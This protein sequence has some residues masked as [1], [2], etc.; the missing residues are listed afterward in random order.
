MESVQSQM[1]HLKELVSVSLDQ[2]QTLLK[3]STDFKDLTQQ[4]AT[5]SP[6]GTAT[7]TGGAL[8]STSS[9][10]SGRLLQE[11]V[12]TCLLDDLTAFKKTA[13]LEQLRHFSESLQ[14]V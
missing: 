13:S 14:K 1:K 5:A 8:L 11:S 3:L 6:S 10:T 7:G 4:T 2:S 12:A 9:F